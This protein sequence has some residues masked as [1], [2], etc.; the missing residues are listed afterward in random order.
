[1]EDAALVDDTLETIPGNTTGRGIVKRDQ[2][3]LGGR[4]R[5]HNI[6]NVLVVGQE[7]G[8]AVIGRKLLLLSVPK[9]CE[10]GWW[11]RPTPVP[12]NKPV[13][14]LPKAIS[15]R[16]FHVPPRPSATGHKSITDL[17]ATSTIFKKLLVK[18]P[19][20]LP[21][22]DQNGYEAPSVPGS[23]VR[24]VRSSERSDNMR[25]PLPSEPTTAM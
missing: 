18:K 2:L 23:G 16:L 3:H 25:V 9:T 10:R 1:M 7:D 6:S 24:L 13:V 20:C 12:R 21:S 14:R 15:P 8:K 4:R 22:G 5:L 17:P 11:Y 19:I